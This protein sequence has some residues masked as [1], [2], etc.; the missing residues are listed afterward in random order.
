MS[1]DDR[2]TA[3][4]CLIDH[5]DDA[6]LWAAKCGYEAEAFQLRATRSEIA[7]DLD[8]LQLGAEEHRRII[9]EQYVAMNEAI[10]RWLDRERVVA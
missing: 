6:E 4:E 3:L 1:R 10:N 7:Y 2:I 5:L 8:E 9:A